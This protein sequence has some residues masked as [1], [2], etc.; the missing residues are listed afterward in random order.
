MKR[1]RGIQLDWGNMD[2]SSAKIQAGDLMCPV[3]LHSSPTVSSCVFFVWGFELLSKTIVNKH[4]TTV[5]VW[6]FASTHEAY[7]AAIVTRYEN[8]AAY[9][10]C[11][12]RCLD[13][14]ALWEAIRLCLRRKCMVTKNRS[15][16][17]LGSGCPML[18]PRTDPVGQCWL[19]QTVQSEYL[20]DYSPC[21]RSRSIKC[22]KFLTFV[23]EASAWH[24][25]A[26][27]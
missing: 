11:T 2:L 24:S 1:T 26:L 25:P 23:W 5:M 19:I 15:V 16:E 21:S 20:V 17:V 12:M 14:L 8:L 18:W 4:A 3:T 7:S 27:S 9:V 13:A 6:R 22:R 10:F